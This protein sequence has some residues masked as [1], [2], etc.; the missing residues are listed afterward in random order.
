MTA[1]TR[2]PMVAAVFA[3]AA[4][5]AGCAGPGE[6]QSSIVVFAAASTVTSLEGIARDFEAEQGNP[7]VVS[8][9]GSATLAQQIEQGAE[10]GVFLSADLAWAD[11]LAERGL[12]AERA[13]FLSNGLV[14]VTPAD[15]L[16]DIRGAAGLADPG[17]E[18]VAIGDPDSAPA[19]TYARAALHQL[20]LWE[21]VAPKAVRAADV[22]QALLYVERGEVDAGIVYAT[23][24]ASSDR[25]REVADLT[26][27]LPEPI[28]YAVALTQTGAND[29]AARSFYEFL[30][31]DAARR[32]FEAAGFRVLNDPGSAAR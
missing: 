17:V 31:S 14:L 23:D 9:A 21:A 1:R 20:G 15:T 24:A 27:H 30:Q 22:R 25:V 13:D 4:I 16:R 10:A 32:R 3:A 12:I 5:S 7:V 11:R 26:P 28:R 29:P 18:R 2:W 19:G 8:Y 6:D